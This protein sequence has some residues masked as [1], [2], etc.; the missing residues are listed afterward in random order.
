[1][2]KSEFSKWR[3]VGKE[4]GIWMNHYAF[5]PERAHAN[6]CGSKLGQ[7]LQFYDFKF[8]RVSSPF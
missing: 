4:D 6:K 7:L 1:M 5:D 8:M 2:C 3:P